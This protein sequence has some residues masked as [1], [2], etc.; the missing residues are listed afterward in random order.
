M[1]LP[2]PADVKP[3][4]RRTYIMIE[5]E[6]RRIL[7]FIQGGATDSQIMKELKIP[8]RMFERR[9]KSIR[10][11]HL[12]EVLDKQTVDA[13][14][15]AMKLCQDKLKWL[16]LQASR[17]IMDPYARHFD[18]LQAI[19]R[20]RILQI[21]QAKLLIEGPTIFKIIPPDGLHRGL[22]ATANELRDT[23]AISEITAATSTTAG[24]ND[25]RQF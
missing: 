25:E 15:S 11:S 18:K 21:D 17:I 7:D 8:R 19:D 1:S 16:E 10:E 5:E 9:M 13:K 2:I 20:I 14:A 23:P 3:R 22:E 6:K 24:T 12:K 4:N